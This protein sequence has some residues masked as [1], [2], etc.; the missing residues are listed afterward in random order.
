V[1]G[2]KTFL[3][4]SLVTGV[5]FWLVMVAQLKLT[6]EIFHPLRYSQLAGANTIVQSLLI[7]IVISPLAGWALDALK[8]W[9]FSL[10]LPLVGDVSFGPYRLV[11][12]MMAVLY[13]AAWFG[14]VQVQRHR[15]ALGGRDDYVAPL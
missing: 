13:G 10:P 4:S 11:N 7:A 8:G 2:P 12:L 6:Q 5:A 3:L 14:V 15:D 9:S 1:V